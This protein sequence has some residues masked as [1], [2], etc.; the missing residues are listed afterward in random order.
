MFYI[1]YSH[2]SVLLNEAIQSLNIKATGI[3]IDGTFGSGGHS[4]LILSQLN[5]RGRLLAIDK[6]LLAIKIGKCI[7]ERDGRFTIIHS[8][9]SKM[10]K[11]VKNIGLIG[12]VDGILLDLGISTFQINDCS[13]GFSFMQD[14]L[15]D[16]RMDISS[17]ISAAEWLSKASQENITWV[18]KTFGEE[19][20]AKNI[21]RVIVS[22]R[23]YMPIIRSIV[24]S[25]LICDA[26]P[27]RN[28]NKHPATKSFLAIRMFI[29]NELEEIMQVLK[30]ALVMLSPRG[31]LV[32]ISF[33][34]LEDRL[35]K[36][37]IRE[38]SCV[39]SIPPKLPLTNNQI[40]S[41]YKNKC[42]LKNIGKLTPSKQEI[43]RNIRAR[44]A[45]LRCA[46]KLLI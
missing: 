44:S 43:K 25:K 24:L 13:R 42:Q 2:K 11:H 3:Y 17:G 1:H 41:K 46:E 8:S 33:N 34:S 21:A 39:L 45:I 5:E 19:R 6:D 29:N 10:I 38:H 31:R 35:V 26:I 20:F 15:L 36:Y 30:D 27:H 12:S 28:M 18:L 9:F 32:V 22:K 16:M 40:F 4:K 14:G 37:F 7:A 23:R